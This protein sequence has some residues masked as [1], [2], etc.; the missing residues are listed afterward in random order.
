MSSSKDYINRDEHTKSNEYL[1]SI[2]DLSVPMWEEDPEAQGEYCILV[3]PPKN[4]RYLDKILERM[5]TNPQSRLRKR[6]SQSKFG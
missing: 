6:C 1:E 5:Q 2:S 4:L 3:P